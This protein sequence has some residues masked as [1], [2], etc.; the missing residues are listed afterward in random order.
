MK[1][2]SSLFNNTTSADAYIL[3]T[4]FAFK[5]KKINSFLS[6]II[7]K[8][9]KSTNHEISIDGF[10]DHLKRLSSFYNDERFGN[11]K[12]VSSD[13]GVQKATRNAVGFFDEYENDLDCDIDFLINPLV[14][15]KD[16]AMNFIRGVIDSRSSAD[17]TTSYIA[18][19]IKRKSSI[20]FTTIL[21]K[22]FETV[23][24]GKVQYNI[25]PRFRQPSEISRL[26][27]PQFRIPYTVVFGTIGTFRIQF[28]EKL[29]L[30]KQEFKKF[31][32]NSKVPSHFDSLILWDTTNIPYR[33][34]VNNFTML[35]GDLEYY[36]VYSKQNEKLIY[37][38]LREQFI[39]GEYKPKEQRKV[40]S[41]DLKDQILKELGVQDFLVPDNEIE[42]NKS[43]DLL[44]DFHHVIPYKFHYMLDF[45]SDINDVKNIVPVRQDTHYFLHRGQMNDKKIEFLKKLFEY[46]KPFLQKHNLDKEVTFDVFKTMY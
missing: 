11:Y 36:K 43:G 41:N 5:Y 38:K 26:K 7:G 39:K 16:F 37:Q 20:S 29:K 17:T 3:G 9:Q 24:H 23:F 32:T 34:R 33:P 22:A 19:D 44:I 21:V 35:E 14:E 31:M 30:N 15:D 13:T 28:F 45:K 6:V 46:A 2:I 10:K 27:N 42:K 1:K 4:I 40:I 8:N 25:N 18:M 12:E